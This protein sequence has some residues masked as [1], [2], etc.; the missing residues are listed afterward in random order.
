MIVYKNPHFSVK[1]IEDY[2]SIVFPLKPVIILPI[3]NN[4]HI[5]F[6]QAIRPVFEKTVIE[7]PAGH[8]ES[9]E[10][11]EMAALR[12]LGEE[13][14][15]SIEDEKRLKMLPSLNTIPSRTAQMLQIYQVNITKE[16]YEKRAPYDHEVAGTLLLTKNQ[17]INKI[18]N[19]EIF[20]AVAVAICLR[21]IIT[22]YKEINYAGEPSK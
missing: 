11:V 15:V 1:V 4:S 21:H 10:T 9:E 7:L 16:E 3:V 2:Y 5:L 6:V 20:V 13:T 18:Q 22:D 17:V 19:G 8:V 14:G 12:E